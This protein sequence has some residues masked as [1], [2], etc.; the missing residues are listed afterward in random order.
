MFQ[1]KCQTVSPYPSLCGQTL[2]TSFLSSEPAFEVS[3]PFLQRRRV[4]VPLGLTSGPSCLGPPPSLFIDWSL[5][6]SGCSV[7]NHSLFEIRIIFVSAESLKLH[8]VQRKTTKLSIYYNVSPFL[9]LPTLQSV[10][11]LTPPGNCL[12]EAP[13][14][15]PLSS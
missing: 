10:S 3:S 2:R 1:N 9:T 4:E 5:Q 6:W 15:G 14:F 8:N 13:L 11:F 7:L 12:T